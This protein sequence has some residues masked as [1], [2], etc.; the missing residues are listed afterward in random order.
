MAD[1]TR[2]YNTKPFAVS[3]DS[4]QGASNLELYDKNNDY[5]QAKEL[6]NLCALYATAYNITMVKRLKT[7]K[8]EFFEENNLNEEE[9][10]Y[11]LT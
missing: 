5:K 10:I 11:N 9:M 7:E 6:D 4:I 1:A 3:Y 8:P 2:P